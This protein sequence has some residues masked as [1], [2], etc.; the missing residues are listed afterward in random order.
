M[1]TQEK[2]AGAAAP[3]TAIKNLQ[4]VDSVSAAEKI[5]THE[6]QSA[7]LV[8]TATKTEARIDTRVLAQHLGSQH[9]S[10]FKLV[11]QHQTDFKELGKVRFQIGAS[12][13]SRTGQT[14][15]FALLNEDQAYLLLTYSRNTARVRALKIQLVK[16]FREA[17]LY[18]D[19]R[20]STRLN[21][22]RQTRIT[23]ALLRGG[24]IWREDVDRIAGASNGPETIRQLRDKGLV[25]ECQR[26]ERT[27]RDGVKCRPGR[28]RLEQ[29]SY[30]LAQRLL[31]A[32]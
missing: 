16:A 24:W 15:K 17:R 28:Y 25:I 9:E 10:I 32:V 2:A 8:L 14:M 31:G 23:R 29:R 22:P 11:T 30:P 12:P 5:G 19:T 6:K 4:S 7:M 26:V 20:K 3:A 18:A 27:D 21:C 13:G 1:T